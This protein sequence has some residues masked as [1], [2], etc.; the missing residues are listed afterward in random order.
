MVLRSAPSFGLSVRV[1]SAVPQSGPAE[2]ELIDVLSSDAVI[3]AALREYTIARVPTGGPVWKRFAELVPLSRQLAGDLYWRCGVGLNHV[4]LVTGQPVMTVRVF[5]CRAGIA[6]RHR[7]VR[8][9]VVAVPAGGLGWHRSPG[10]AGALT[11]G[12]QC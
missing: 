5:V 2:I 8:R 7:G 4:E 6:L 3:E 12:G 1:G 9:R 11:P 10:F